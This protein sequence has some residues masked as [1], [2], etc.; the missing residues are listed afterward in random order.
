MQAV[1]ERHANREPAAEA[2]SSAHPCPRAPL[3]QEVGPVSSLTPAAGLAGPTGCGR[4]DDV[5]PLSLAL[6]G[7]S[8]RLHPLQSQLPA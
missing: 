3:R 6:R 7:P 5:L 8:F 2:P 4:S 1:E